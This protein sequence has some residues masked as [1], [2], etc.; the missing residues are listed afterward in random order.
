MAILLIIL[1]ASLH[2][3]E[4]DREQ[5]LAEDIKYSF[6][7]KLASPF[8]E[9]KAGGLLDCSAIGLGYMIRPSVGVDIWKFSLHVGVDIQK[10]AYAIP[11]YSGND[12]N[13]LKFDGLS[14]GMFGNAG[15]YF[16]VTFKF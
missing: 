13:D 6:M 9:L 11:R 8:V 1:P 2:A 16:G 7:N 14:Q 4:T 15:P 12:I 3:Q 5:V 10:C